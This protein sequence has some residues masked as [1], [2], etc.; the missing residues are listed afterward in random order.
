MCELFF[1]QN[2]IGENR[3][4]NQEWT[5]HRHRKHLKQDTKRIQKKKN[6]KQNNTNK[7]TKTKQNKQINK[8]TNK[9]KQ[10]TTTIYEF[11]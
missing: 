3:R 9:T 11:R 4:E 2:N 1:L 8:Q 10:S 7:Q 6:K 5:I